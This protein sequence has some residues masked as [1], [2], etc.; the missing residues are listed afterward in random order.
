MSTNISRMITGL[1]ALASVKEIN[2]I[3]IWGIQG[4][5]D[6]RPHLKAENEGEKLELEAEMDTD[7]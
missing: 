5:D 3:R 6:E 4:W 2:G 7:K 1:I